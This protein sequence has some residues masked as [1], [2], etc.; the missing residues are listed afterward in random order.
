MGIDDSV[1]APV[2][3]CILA[4]QKHELISGVPDLPLFLDLDL[5]ILGAP[6]GLYRQ[7]SEAIG[8]EYNWVPGPV[9]PRPPGGAETLCAAANTVRY[10][11]NVREI[12]SAGAPQS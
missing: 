7:Y 3:R 11:G 6:Y 2:E 4:T 1:I 10:G 12:R 8:A 5:A 9:S